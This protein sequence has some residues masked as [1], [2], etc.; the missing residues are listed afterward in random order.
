MRNL[1]TLAIGNLPNRF[2]RQRFD[3]LSV[4][5]KGD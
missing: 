4:Q 5:G 3:R 1:D 2:A